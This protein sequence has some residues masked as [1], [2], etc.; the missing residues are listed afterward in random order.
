MQWRALVVGH[1]PRH[2]AGSISNST[3]NELHFKLGGDGRCMSPDFVFYLCKKL[4]RVCSVAVVENVFRILQRVWLLCGG[5]Q[6]AFILIL[7]GL[8][9][10]CSYFIVRAPRTC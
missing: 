1:C 7:S 3:V 4:S 5:G 8:G 10:Y 2:R 6:C 9:L